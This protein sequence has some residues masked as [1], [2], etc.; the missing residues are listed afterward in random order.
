MCKTKLLRQ[1]L[2][3]QLAQQQRIAQKQKKK[4]L[5]RKGLRTKR[6]TVQPA[7]REQASRAIAGHLIDYLNHDLACTEIRHCATYIASDGEIDPA[8]LGELMHSNAICLYIPRIICVE[9]KTMEFARWNPG[10]SSVAGQYGIPTASGAAVDPATL[11]LILCPLV[12]W[13]GTGSRLGM[14]GGYYDRFLSQGNCNA[15]RIGL[16]FEIQ[17]EDE[18]DRCSGPAD[19]R[20]NAVVTEQGTYSFR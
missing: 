15:H 1:Q 12:G 8:L 20:L 16:G 19:I 13:S 11:D 10:S 3:Q 6:K 2:G 7:I 17:R 4:K 18:I 5:L 14:G 9:N